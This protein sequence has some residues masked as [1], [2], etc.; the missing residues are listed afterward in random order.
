MGQLRSLQDWFVRLQLSAVPGVAEVA[1]IG[2]FVRQYQVDVN[3]NQLRAYGLPLS[4]VVEQIQGS[5]RNVG[6]GNIEINGRDITIRGVALVRSLED[7][8]SIPVGYFQG[9]PVLLEQIATVAMGPEPRRG[10]LDVAGREAVGG[11]VVMRY[12]ESARE[13]IAG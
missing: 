3:P 11:V 2:G 5:S 7:L 6:G 10:V 9:R 4:G 1:S 12:G 8:Q 13:V